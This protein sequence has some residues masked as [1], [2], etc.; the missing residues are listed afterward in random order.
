MTTIAPKNRFSLTK[1]LLLTLSFL[2]VL[3]VGIPAAHADDHHGFYHRHGY[4]RHHYYHHG[5]GY[6]HYRYEH[7]RRYYYYGDYRPGIEL[8][9]AP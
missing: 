2:A 9:I 1:K 8:H 5:Y 6:R 4:Y 3:A 7:G